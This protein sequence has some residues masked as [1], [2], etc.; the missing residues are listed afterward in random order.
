MTESETHPLELLLLFGQHLA[1]IVGFLLALLLVSRVLRQHS[2]PDTSIAWFLFMVL[3][4]WVGVPAYLIFGGRKIDNR[5]G[6]KPELHP[7]SLLPTAGDIGD[8]SARR[9]LACGLP[10]P[11]VGNAIELVTDGTE[12]Y[13][14]LLALIDG[15]RESIHLTTF[16]FADDAVGRSLVTRLAARAQEGVA[17]RVLVDAVG[18]LLARAWRL[19]ELSRAGAE[20]GVFMPVLPLRRRWSANLR[21]HRKLAIFD[22]EIV[23]TGG[24]N[25]ATEYMGPAL[26]S[27]SGATRWI[28]TCVEVRGPAVADFAQIFAQ[29]WAFATGCS[30]AVGSAPEPIGETTLQIAPTG[31]DVAGDPFYDVLTAAIHN[32]RERVWIVTPY[33]VPDE[34]LLRALALQARVGVDVRLILPRRSNHRIADL[35]RNRLL[36]EL[37]A[38][39]VRVFLHPHA[40]IHAKHIVIDERVAITGSVNM[41]AR[42]LYV[43]YELA[44]FAYGRVAATHDAHWIASVAARCEETLPPRP[45]VLGRWGEDLS[46]LLSPLI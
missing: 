16:I 12:A 31:P 41:D 42:S 17:V 25:L 22:G 35:A 46:W 27:D 37:G 40:M 24:M 9:L 10:P 11:R 5:A 15:A 18:S 13:E 45:G 8:D 30:V 43:N 6:R 7:T 44:M 38:T 3:A 14:R 29:D 2:R 39:G 36:R 34:G 32:A 33:F 23:L 28:D 19:R 4:P 20:V 26:P 21:N 1:T